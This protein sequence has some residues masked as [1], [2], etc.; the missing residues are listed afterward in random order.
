MAQYNGHIDVY[1]DGENLFADAVRELRRTS[2]PDR[3]GACWE[4]TGSEVVDRER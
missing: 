4:M 1:S 2:F 3:G